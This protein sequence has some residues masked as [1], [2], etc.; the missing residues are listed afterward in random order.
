ET[1]GLDF[2]KGPAE[3][4]VFGRAKLNAL[5]SKNEVAMLRLQTL[6]FDCQFSVSTVSPDGWVWDLDRADVRSPSAQLS[7]RDRQRRRPRVH[8]IMG[9]SPKVLK[10]HARFLRKSC[11]LPKMK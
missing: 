2:R 4:R 7:N 3:S 10:T 1:N 9:L 8:A 5:F 11:R 6:T